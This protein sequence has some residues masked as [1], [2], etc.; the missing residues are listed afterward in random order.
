MEDL[1]WLVSVCRVSLRNTLVAA[2]TV[3][4]LHTSFSL[5][6]SIVFYWLFSIKHQD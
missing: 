6:S 1:A 5:K 2:F 4:E 3:Q